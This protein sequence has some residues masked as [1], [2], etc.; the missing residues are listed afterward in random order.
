MKKQLINLEPVREE[1]K[2]KLL[3]QYDATVFMNTSTVELRLSVE[4]ILNKYIEEQHIEEPTVYIT[5]NAYIKM[6]MLVD[7]TDKEIGWYGIVEQVPGL[8][9]SY[10]IEDI[11][12]YPQKVT[13]ATVEQDENRM[14][15]F[16]TSLTTEQVNHKRFQGHS[17]VNMSTTPS[18]VDENFYQDLLSQVNDYFII[19][20]TNKRNE[21]TTRFYDI[22]NN[23]LYTDVPIYLI[24]QDGTLYETWFAEQKE[25]VAEHTI[26]R[27]ENII[28]ITKNKKE[29]KKEKKEKQKSIFDYENDYPFWDP[30]LYD[31]IT[32]DEYEDIYGVPYKGQ[33][34]NL[35]TNRKLGAKNGK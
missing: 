25:K 30:N 4:D 35:Y 14:F 29:N 28:N 16:E 2:Q 1:V 21:Y 18:G 15:E 13:G 34:D 3:E 22:T 7:K 19:T 26:I 5:P 6:R 9:S 24:Q 12:V 31:Y 11:I 20:I 23:I 17:H 33:Y 27:D 10:I 8:E 32:A